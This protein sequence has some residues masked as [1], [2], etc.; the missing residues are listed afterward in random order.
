MKHKFHIPCPEYTRYLKIT[1]AYERFKENLSRLQDKNS[2]MHKSIHQ[3]LLQKHGQGFDFEKEFTSLANGYS[4]KIAEA[5]KEIVALRNFLDICENY[6]QYMRVK[7]VFDP[8]F[9][10]WSEADSNMGKQNLKTGAQFQEKV[11][12]TMIPYLISREKAN[13]NWP[14]ASKTF[15]V[16]TNASWIPKSLGE[17][18]IAFGYKD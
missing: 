6:H 11:N 5:E 3:G 7:R 16:F 15:E 8:Y 14:Y 2:L 18:D 1:Q 4:T 17:I 12:N 9:R 13:P 10:Q